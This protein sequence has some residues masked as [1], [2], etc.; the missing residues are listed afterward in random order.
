MPEM[1]DVAKLTEQS[2][3]LVVTIRH[4]LGLHLR[5]SRDVV[6]TANQFRAEITAQNV[7]RATP[8]YDA[9]SIL[10][11]MQLQARPGHQVQ[12]SATGPDAQDA[13]AALRTLFESQSQRTP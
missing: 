11:L 5:K 6:Q 9:K 10:Q 1:L 8:A 12:L 2:E 13:L 3:T 7:S 4:P